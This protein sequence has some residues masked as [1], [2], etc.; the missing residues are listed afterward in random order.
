MTERQRQPVRAAL[1]EW[2]RMGVWI[3][4]ASIVAVTLVAIGR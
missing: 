2:A 4:A 3:L 1:V